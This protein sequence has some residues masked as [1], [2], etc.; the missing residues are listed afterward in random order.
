VRPGQVTGLPDETQVAAVAGLYQAERA[1]NMTIGSAVMA[2]IGGAIAY[3]GLTSLAGA[4][5][6][7]FGGVS[8]LPFLP[9]PL[10]A[11]VI[12]Q[13]GRVWFWALVLTYAALFVLTAVSWWTNIVLLKERERRRTA[14]I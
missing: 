12:Y 4:P 3:V 6:Q 9:F 11:L 5:N 8:V 13:L 7:V 1:D 2:V 10:W 14:D